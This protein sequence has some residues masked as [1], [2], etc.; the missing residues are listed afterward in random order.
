[1]G[2][3]DMMEE[4]ANTS[5]VL[6]PTDERLASISELANQQL[7]LQA[8]LADLE[9]AVALKKADLSLVQ[10]VKLPAAMEAARMSEFKLTDGA[11]VTIKKNVLAG[12]TAEHEQEAMAWLAETGNDGIIK[13]EVVLGFGKGQD[14]EAKVLTT[15]LDAQG[16]SYTASRFV[17]P[18]TLKAF[19]RKRLEAGE[20]IPLDTFSVFEKKSAV[21][22]LPK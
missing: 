13:N 21:I 19:V 5:A 1:M 15:L 3:A 7:R 14:N 20:P 9:N 22:K 16:Y 2:I 12:I 8:E 11:V 6:L 10:E 18:Q 17:H 4:D